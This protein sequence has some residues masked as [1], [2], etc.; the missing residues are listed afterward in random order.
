MAKVF[1]IIEAFDDS[2]IGDRWHTF[3]MFPYPHTVC[4]IQLEGED[5][6]IS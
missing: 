2:L 5:G 3:V 4:G 1:Q 6:V